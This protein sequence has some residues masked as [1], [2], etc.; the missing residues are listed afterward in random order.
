MIPLIGLRI[1]CCIDSPND[2]GDGT[3]VNVPGIGEPSAS[4]RY[5]PA[6][7]KNAAT[8]TSTVTMASV[9]TAEGNWKVRFGVVSCEAAGMAP[10]LRR[11]AAMRRA[12]P[13]M[14][15]RCPL[16]AVRLRRALD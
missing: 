15:V 11:S 5:R 1:S 7:M 10:N 16:F 3:C 8:H 14:I 4:S 6:G 13:S 9:V 12:H 2:N